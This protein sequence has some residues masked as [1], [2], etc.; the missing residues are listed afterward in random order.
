MPKNTTNYPDLSA[1][2]VFFEKWKAL[3]PPLAEKL[4]AFFQKWPGY[5]PTENQMSEQPPIAVDH[6][7]SLVDFFGSFPS[8][9]K[10]RKSQGYGLN[11][12]NIAG[13]GRDEL[14]N[15]AILFWWLRQDGEHSLGKAILNGILKTIK[16]EYGKSSIH[17]VT[18]FTDDYQIHREHTQWDQ[19]GRACRLDILIESKDVLMVIE[20]KINAPESINVKG[21]D[22]QLDRYCELARDRSGKKQWAVV[23][24]TPSKRLDGSRRKKHP[25]LFEITW[26]E[27]ANV[28]RKE[29]KKIEKGNVIRVLLE[30][31]YN[32]I[33]TF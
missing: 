17:K 31:T 24:L 14:R 25:E 23:Y 5:I 7:L 18:D 12:W 21:G 1:L 26:K 27:V 28:I 10:A 22:A 15:M 19:Q 9:I 4:Q 11:I 29:S 32:T 8:A 3:H 16:K 2:V 13:V 6:V 30:S 20:G 33:T